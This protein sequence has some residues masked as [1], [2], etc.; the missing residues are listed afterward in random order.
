MVR[1][2]LLNFAPYLIWGI[3]SLAPYQANA[4]QP[5]K[6]FHPEHFDP[7]YYNQFGSDKIIPKEISN[8][9][10]L[11]LSF[12][13]ELKY[14]KI[15]FSLCERHSPLS[16]RPTFISCFKRKRNRKF[17]ISISTKTSEKLSPILF[18]NLPYNA[19]VGVLGHELSHVSDFASRGFFGLIRIG[20]GHVSKK[21]MDNFENKTDMI[22]IRHGLGYQLMEW[23]KYV[24]TALQIQEWYG[25]D[26]PESFQKRSFKRERYMSPPSIQ[27]QID[28]LTLYR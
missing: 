20:V 10:L 8:Q 27:H 26:N 3:F 19:Q 6:Q 2:F 9:V 23:S 18:E 5:V 1:L 24:R 13:P 11:A 15:K 28:L 7:V 22:C 21:F 4:Q 14:A 17:V 25:A 12:F 16:S